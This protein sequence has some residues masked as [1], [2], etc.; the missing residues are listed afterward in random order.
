VRRWRAACGDERRLYE[1]P[2]HAFALR[3]GWDALLA[4]KP[5]RHLLLLSHGGRMEIFHG[6]ARRELPAN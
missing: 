5:G 3:L 1:A 6:F 2:G 4:V